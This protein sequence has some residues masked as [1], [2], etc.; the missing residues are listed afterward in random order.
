MNGRLTFSFVGI[1]L[2]MLALIG[3]EKI[4]KKTIIYLIMIF[5]GFIFSSVS[6][7]TQLIYLLIISIY[8]ITNIT[9]KFP[10]IK[11]IHF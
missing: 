1:S 4:D 8:I 2:L 6:S 10:K 3:I 7:G 11:N 5:I 9:M